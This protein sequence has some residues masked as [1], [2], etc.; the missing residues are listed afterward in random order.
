MA[1]TGA[2]QL[3]TNKYVHQTGVTSVLHLYVRWL[4]AAAMEVTSV[5][6]KVNVEVQVYCGTSVP[7]TV[8]SADT[9]SVTPSSLL[10]TGAT[11]VAPG[12][13]A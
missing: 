4:P 7:T 13:A 12:R 1:R 3:K 9:D 8:V 5:P 2:K 11:V 10:V 6:V